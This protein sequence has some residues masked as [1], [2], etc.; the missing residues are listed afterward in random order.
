MTDRVVNF[1]PGPAVLPLE[2]LTQA[3]DDL[4][5]LPGIGISPLEISH[6]SSWFDGVL[7]ETEANLRR[8]LSLPDNYR[9][10][11]MQGGAR[12]QFSLIPLNLLRGRTQP[13]DYLVT[14]TWSQMAV[15]E[16]R[17]EGQVRVV[18]DGQGAQFSRLPRPDEYFVGSDAAYAYYTS[19]ET[20]Q[21]VQFLSEPVAGDVPLICDASSD[22]LCRPL[23]ME[24]YALVYAC[25]QK[26]LGPAGVTI[27]IL[28]DDLL[29]RCADGLHTVLSYKQC[30]K[31]KS[32]LN[33][34]PVFAV[35]IVLLVTRW[36]LDRVG[37]LAAMEALNR[38]KANLLYTLI[39]QSQGF[40]QGHAEPGSRSLMNV[41]FRL[42][43]EAT[44]TAF[45]AGARERGLAEL[46]GHRSVGG[47]RAS[48]YNAMP[49]EGVWAL[50][51]YLREFQVYSRR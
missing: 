42:P 8:L 29:G 44:Q 25:A 20:I 39:D 19:N 16:A 24:K 11:F 12:L 15:P 34:P 7:A 21:G 17:K 35:Y 13:A 36:L 1:S 37:G 28:R 30:A 10:L 50:A 5:A 4:L 45:L 41:T 47:I 2:V 33:T 22:F 43:D 31:E 27:V 23:P 38:Q 32:L 40:Y 49:L 46:K 26:N 18:Y 51:D 3:R 9:V 14:G 48:I 6:R